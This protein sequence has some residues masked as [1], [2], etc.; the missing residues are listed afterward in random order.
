M[1]HGFEGLAGLLVADHL[2]RL[3]GQILG[4]VVAL[5]RRGRRLDEVVVLDEVRIP[6]VGLAADEPVVALEPLAERPRLAVA[7]LGDILL[8]ER[9][10]SCRARRCCS[11]CPGGSAPTVAACGGMRPRPAREI[12]WTPSVIAAMPFKVWLRPVRSVDRVGEHSATVCHCVYV[13]PLL[14][15][16]SQRRHVD[17]AAVGR[18]G[19]EPGVV[20]Q[21]EQD[22]RCA[23][24]RLLRR[25]RPPVG[26]RIADIELDGA[27]EILVWPDGLGLGAPLRSGAG[28]FLVLGFGSHQADQYQTEGH[29]QDP[30]AR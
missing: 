8:R 17:P 3:I 10:G 13:R 24:G 12:R 18:P 5:L 9:C 28:R 25:E 6:L 16:L 11:R 23:L 7:A 1:N 27:L 15:S 22:V 4:E 19:G 30:V 20:V 2:D 26:D 29:A 14:A 21:H